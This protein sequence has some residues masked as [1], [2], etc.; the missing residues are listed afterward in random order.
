MPNS[1]EDNHSVVIDDI[2]SLAFV[3]ERQT[4]IISLTVLC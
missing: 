4:E 3:N 2:D 1:L